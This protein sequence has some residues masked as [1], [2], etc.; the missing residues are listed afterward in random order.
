MALDR[1]YSKSV[2][3]IIKIKSDFFEKNEEML[4]LSAH[5]ADALLAQPKRAVCKIC[6]GKPLYG[7]LPYNLLAS[8]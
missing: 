3:D 5:Q 4:K 2:G 7:P 8:R 1:K 6:H